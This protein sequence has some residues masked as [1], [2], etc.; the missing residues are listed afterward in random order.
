[1]LRAAQPGLRACGHL[2]QSPAPPLE[3]TCGMGPSPLLSV[4]W[5]TWLASHGALKHTVVKC[6]NCDL[7][8]NSGGS[9]CAI[10]DTALA[11]AYKG[12]CSTCIYMYVCS[13]CCMGQQ[14]LSSSLQLKGSQCLN[15]LREEMQSQGSSTSSGEVKGAGDTWVKAGETPPLVIKVT[16]LTKLPSLSFFSDPLSYPPTCHACLS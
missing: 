4:G 3:P 13:G 10:I 12:G 16:C 9:V 7:R 11:V 8:G 1:M 15:W 14:P 2:V 6:S 5:K